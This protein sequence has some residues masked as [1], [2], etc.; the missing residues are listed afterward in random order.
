[1]RGGPVV[2]WMSREQRVNDNWALCF[3]QSEALEKKVPLVVLFCQTPRFLDATQQQYHFLLRGLRE[4]KRT[5]EEKNISFFLLHGEPESRVPS[6]IHE[7]GAGMLITDQNPLRLTRE[8]KRGVASR[9]TIPMLDIDAHNIVPVWIASQ[10]LEYGAYTLRPKL[11]RLL[12]EFLDDYPPIVKHPFTATVPVKSIDWDRDPSPTPVPVNSTSSLVCE[13]GEA[14][15]LVVLR[16]FIALRMQRYDTDRNDPMLEGQS[17]LSPYLHFGHV[18][19]QRVA[20]EV[21]RA[22][23]SPSAAAFLEELIVRR[24]LSDNFCLYNNAYD[25]FDG[26]PA[27]AQQSLNVHRKDARTH[28]YTLEQFEAAETHDALWNAAQR[29]MLRTGRMH[30]FMRM[31]WAKKILE[32]TASPEEAIAIAIHLNDTY[33]LDGRDPNGYAGIAWSIGGVHDRAWIERPVYGKIRYMNAK[34][35][36]RKFDVKAYC[37]KFRS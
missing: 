2:Y 23:A 5:L 1:Y 10:K 26:F 13:P 8:W 15:A 24:E 9:I 22:S 29:E 36:A 3:A 12:P 30:G 7:C 4:V 17:H 32:W 16:N 28:L 27:W 37:D 14:A 19:A 18:S 31:Y 11:H 33:E 6:F 35:C 34:G 25:S 20:L 21:Q